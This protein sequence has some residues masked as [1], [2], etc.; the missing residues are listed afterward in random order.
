[1]LVN[2]E[3]CLPSLLAPA[4][5]QLKARLEQ[6][7]GAEA[8]LHICRVGFP[9]HALLVSVSLRR[10]TSDGCVCVWGADIVGMLELP[11]KDVQKTTSVQEAPKAH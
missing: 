2:S 8:L 3:L 11:A 4:D 6:A 10:E 5:K 1:M 9:Q 7:A